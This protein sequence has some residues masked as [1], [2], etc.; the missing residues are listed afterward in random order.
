MRSFSSL[1][2]TVIK[3]LVRFIIHTASTTDGRQS[4]ST[5][6]NE[7]G[8]TGM[9]RYFNEYGLCNI[10]EP[11]VIIQRDNISYFLGALLDLLF[12]L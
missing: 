10:L 6:F 1:G 8:P 4:A 12:G 7:D 2:K 5:V 9:N 11:I 3:Q